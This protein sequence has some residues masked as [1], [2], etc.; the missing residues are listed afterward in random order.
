MRSHKN[1]LRRHAVLGVGVSLAMMASFAIVGSG[2]SS[3]SQA[4]S[5]SYKLTIG[6]LHVG[7]IYDA[8]YNEAQQAGITYLEAHMTGVR[9]L[10]A[11]EVPETNVVTD[12]MQTMINEGAKLIFPMDF[13][14][15]AFAYPLSQ[16]NPTV[17]FEQP[18]GYLVGKNF[19]DYWANSDDV[20]YALGAAAAKMVTNGKLGFI[21]SLPIA[22]IICSA[23]AFHLGAQSVNK[24]ITTRVIWTD[25]WSNPAAETAAVT[26]LHSD[27]VKV[28]GTL[29]DSPVA[30]LKQAAKYHMLVVAY[31]SAVGESVAPSAW[32]SSDAFNWGPMFVKM[33]KAVEA[34]T[35]GTSVYDSNY[36]APVG[37][38][39]A[40]M[41]PWGPKVTKAAEK[42]GNSSFKLF[43]NGK[44]LNPYKGPIYNQAGVLEVPAGQYL[45]QTEQ[46]SV[47]WLAKGMIGTTS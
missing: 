11:Q 35:W 18:G 3:A 34:G 2:T 13:G 26:T 37:T 32:L 45:T 16:S 27:G 22:S 41:A 46:A 24:A 19:G 4:P 30:V 8:G 6:V 23:I 25:S 40:Y 14:Y 15:Q 28:I 5:S 43:V 21:G 17:V 12:D 9:V 10:M 44:L 39:T 47:T 31:Q 38:L 42:V 36:V 7:S 29:L 20:D 1:H 33:A